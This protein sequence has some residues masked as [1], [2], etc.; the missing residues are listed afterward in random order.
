MDFWVWVAVLISSGIAVHALRRTLSLRKEVKRLTRNEYDRDSRMREISGETKDTLETIRI[1]L[2][3]LAAG[4]PVAE[5]LIR[6]GRLYRDIT[7]EALTQLLAGE[8]KTVGQAYILDV[9]TTREYAVRHLP[10]AQSIPL[11]ELENR[12]DAEI[13]QTLQALIVYCASG[14]RSQLACDFLSRR[15]YAFV[16]HLIGGMQ[17]WTGPTEGMG[18]AQLIQIQSGSKKPQG[19]NVGEKLSPL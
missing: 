18:N 15:G 9:R 2:A 8:S 6:S 14:D 13:P 1:Q 5:D 11:E 16:H 17:Q 10:M 19:I 7:T 12:C 4:K 3:L